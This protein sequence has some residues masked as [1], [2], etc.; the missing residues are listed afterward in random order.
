[1]VSAPVRRQ[2]WSSPGQQR[3]EV[4]RFTQRA[5][6]GCLVVQEYLAPVRA[7]WL[8]PDC[9]FMPDR[10][11]CP[12]AGKLGNNMEVGQMDA[13]G[14]HEVLHMSLFLAQAVE[15]QLLDHAQIQ[16]NPRWRELAE[17]ANDALLTLYQ[18]IGA[19]DAP[20]DELARR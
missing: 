12:L 15:E 3:L 18:A 13:Y 8:S 20:P 7:Q 11:G 6:A 17:R 4:T 2:Q 10:A 14:R 1:M 16:A 19:P 9:L 5:T